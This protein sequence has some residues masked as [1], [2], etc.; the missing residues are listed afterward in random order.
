MSHNHLQGRSLADPVVCSILA[1]DY[2]LNQADNFD[3]HNEDDYEAGQVYL[4]IRTDQCFASTD[5]AN[6]ETFTRQ[7]QA[8]YSFVEKHPN[9]CIVTW[10]DVANLSDP[11]DWCLD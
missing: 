8:V 2:Q 5:I 10:L 9:R 7:K 4:K 1:D 11:D 3:F 6:V